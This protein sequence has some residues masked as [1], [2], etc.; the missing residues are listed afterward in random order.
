MTLRTSAHGTLCAA[1]LCLAL[2]GCRSEQGSD[3]AAHAVDEVMAAAD[4]IYTP[5]GLETLPEA[6]I[7]H[8]LTDHEWYAR[9]EPLQ[10]DGV[11]YEPAGAPIAVSLPEMEQVGAYRGV[12]YYRR[13]QDP[14][15]VLYVP[16][17]QGWWQPFR[18]AQ[19]PRNGD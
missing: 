7:Y 12:D 15:P 6:R 19:Q 14:A 16:V 10:H 18:A 13:V 2:A 4:S 9:A 17:F 5:A 1:A 11:P 8:T 3:A